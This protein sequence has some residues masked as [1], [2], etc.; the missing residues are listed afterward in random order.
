MSLIWSLKYL[1]HA[2]PVWKGKLMLFITRNMYMIYRLFSKQVYQWAYKCLH[3]LTLLVDHLSLH[4][5]SLSR[6]S[7]TSAHFCS[8]SQSFLQS[9]PDRMSSL[10]LVLGLA[11][12]H[13]SWSSHPYPRLTKKRLGGLSGFTGNCR[14]QRIAN[15][16][17]HLCMYMSKIV[18]WMYVYINAYIYNIIQRIKSLRSSA[19]V[20]RLSSNLYIK[21][22]DEYGGWQKPKMLRSNPML[23]QL[24][25]SIKHYTTVDPVLEPE[26]PTLAAQR[27]KSKLPF[28]HPVTAQDGSFFWCTP[29]AEIG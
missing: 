14:L 7:P 19:A 20:F 27:G 25:Q 1:H 18:T 12:S 9:S 8:C 15:L 3:G 16:W 17:R 13:Q 29:S 22:S 6:P 5:G 2:A 24:P 26:V 10:C 4:K 11:A 28:W 23:D 21:R